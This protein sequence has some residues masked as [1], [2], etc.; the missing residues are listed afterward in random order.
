[1]RKGI[2]LF[3]CLLVPVANAKAEDQH[4]P[5]DVYIAPEYRVRNE[6]SNCVWCAAEDV[7]YGAGGFES[8]KGVMKRARDAGWHGAMM[9]HV[10]AY[11]Q[12]VGVDVEYSYRADYD[13]LKRAVENGTGAYIGVPGHAIA[14]LGIDRE[15]V[16]LL[17]N[18]PGW[19]GKIEIRHVPLQRFWQFFS[20]H[21]CFP[22]NPKNRAKP[23]WK[24][25]GGY[26]A[27]MQGDVQIGSWDP[28]TQT[29]WE[30]KGGKIQKA[31]PPW[32]SSK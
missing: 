3:L 27:L 9:S 23:E 6:R 18:N 31:M 11:A 19:N 14:L 1:M 20:R 12:K 7:F 26:Q 28:A 15:G 4:R 5:G 22:K 30:H 2:L 29:Y 10:M 25:M 8:F 21:A 13:F 17:D 24:D 16:R 32:E